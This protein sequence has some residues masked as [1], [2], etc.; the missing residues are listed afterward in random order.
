MWS[1]VSASVDALRSGATV[2]A[3]AKV[4]RI[5]RFIGITTASFHILNHA[6]AQTSAP[7]A[8]ALINA[9]TAAM[10]TVKL[11]SLQYTATGSFFATGNAYTSG[12]MR[13]LPLGGLAFRA[14]DIVIEPPAVRKEHVEERSALRAVLQRMRDDSDVVTGLECRLVP[15]LATHDVRAA[16]LHVPRPHDFG[17]DTCAGSDLD[18][19]V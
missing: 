8:G 14:G 3:N 4:R 2:T 11:R 1:Y 16:A 15:P 17:I 18:N 7:H 13:H 12:P 19:D 10:G 6:G 5:V 9:A